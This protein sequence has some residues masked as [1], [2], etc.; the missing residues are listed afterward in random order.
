MKRK[1]DERETG[2]GKTKTYDNRKLT[3]CRS[4]FV[5]LIGEHNEA[6]G[7][8]CRFLTGSVP[9]GE[10]LLQ[11]TWLKA[12]SAFRI[13]EQTWNRTYLRSV[14]YH[15][16]IDRIRKKRQESGLDTELE[17]AAA[18]SYDPLKMWA[19]ADL[20]LRILTSDQRTVYLLIEYLRFTAA[21]TAELL[22]TTEG[23]VKASLHRARKKLDEWRQ[24]ESETLKSTDKK[25]VED[26]Q[27]IF[28]FMEAIRL[29][30][31]RALLI[32]RNGG[33]GEEAA[34]AI[35]CTSA[36]RSGRTAIPLRQP[37]SDPG[38]RACFPQPRLR[39]A[40]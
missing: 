29:Q 36:V 27:A 4:E 33:S 12:W 10:D 16:R 34:L 21:E 9:D 24:P 14:A 30:D 32:L 15:A 5:K 38:I 26:E 1:H 25:Q 6:L 8:Y 2:I 17:T 13:G 20:L 3:E 31:V 7:K 35:R 19:V 23:G 11:E 39:Q 18:Y 22:G 28:A 40:V 37:D